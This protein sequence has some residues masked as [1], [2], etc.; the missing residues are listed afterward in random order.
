[1][2]VDDEP[3]MRETL[4]LALRLHGHEVTLARDGVEALA[5]VAAR[6]P[7]ALVLDVLMP[8]ID[9]FE[10]CRRL[11]RAG[12]RT[13]VLLLTARDGVDDRVGGLDAGADDYLVKPF[14]LQELMARLRA[15][16]RRATPPGAGEALRFGELALDPGAAELRRGERRVELSATE[17]QLLELFLRHPRQVLPRAVLCEHL[18]GYEPDASNGLDVYVFRLRRKLEADGEPR[19]LHTVRGVGYVL[20][21]P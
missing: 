11:R 8:R 2:V 5:A 20:R 19:V 16:T 6:S 9:G 18:W 21:E 17:L 14:A 10:V 7:D 12:D 13:P 4:E 15:I 1:M 3:A